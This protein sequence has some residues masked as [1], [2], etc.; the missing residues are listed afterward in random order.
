MADEYISFKASISKNKSKYAFTVQL[1]NKLFNFEIKWN[2]YA[3]CAFVKIFDVNMN[4]VIKNPRALVNN[5]LIRTDRR[6]LPKDLRFINI[7]GETYEPELNNISE[8]FAFIY[9]Y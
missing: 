3:N 4:P 9:G 5:L 7:N 2:D 6:L 8:E 1:E